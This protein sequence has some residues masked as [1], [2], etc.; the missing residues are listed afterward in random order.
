MEHELAALTLRKG[1]LLRIAQHEAGHAV[2]AIVEKFPF[3]SVTIVPKGDI[4]GNCSIRW[5]SNFHPDAEVDLRT[6][7]RLESAIISC[8]AGHLAEKHFT[9]RNNWVRSKTDLKM[10][11]DLA[12]YLV[13]S[14]KEMEAYLKWLWIR[15]ENLVRQHQQEIV[16]LAVALLN[17][18]T[19]K[20]KRAREI[21]LETQRSKFGITGTLDVKPL[22]REERQIAAVSLASQERVLDVKPLN[23][24]EGQPD[25]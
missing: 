19:I 15:T 5:P 18:K 6:A 21:F 1:E 12:S 8:Q 2:A 3:R 10:V 11:I 4:V 23:R 16:A 14:D 20:A 17:E 7:H 22:N 24:K 13:G 25:D 9:G